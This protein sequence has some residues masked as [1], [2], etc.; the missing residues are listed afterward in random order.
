[1]NTLITFLPAILVLIEHFKVHEMRLIQLMFHLGKCLLL[2]FF[3]S[4]LLP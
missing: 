3:V 4:D 1:M 2:S